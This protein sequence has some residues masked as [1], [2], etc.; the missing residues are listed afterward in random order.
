MFAQMVG[1]KWVYS[2]SQL[3]L[4]QTTSL[5]TSHAHVEDSS[6]ICS[7]TEEQ[8]L[9]LARVTFHHQDMGHCL[10]IALSHDQLSKGL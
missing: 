3:P 1:T 8:S 7:A 9:V 5:V 4:P 6:L 2:P 10:F